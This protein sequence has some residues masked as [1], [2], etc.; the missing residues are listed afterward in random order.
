MAFILGDNGPNRLE[1]TSFSDTIEG[2]GGNDI[3][4]G[5]GGDDFLFGG[6]DNDDLIGGSGINE[7]T[8]DS[9][10][11]WFVMSGR[12]FADFS[13]D[14]ILDFE[15]GRDSIDVSAWG[16]SDF[17]QIRAILKADGLGDA[18]FDAMYDGFR[19][20][21]TLDNVRPNQLLSTDFIYSSSLGR[22]EVGTN[23][24][25][26]MF[27]SA[28]AD[29][30]EGRN[31]SDTLLGG[32]GD[33]ELFGQDGDDQLFGAAGDDTLEGG[34]GNDILTGASGRDL[35]DAGRGRDSLNGGTSHDTLFGG[36]G[37]DKMSGAGGNDRMEG[38][39]GNDSMSGGS[40]DDDLNG[41]SGRDVL[42][43]GSGEDGFIFTSASHSRPGSARDFIRDFQPGPDFIDVEAIDA[44]TRFFGNQDFEF[45]GPNA[46]T[47]AG[48]LRYFVSG[49]RTIVAGNTDNDSAAEFEIELF[50]AI[51]L[52][53]SDFI[54]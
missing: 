11:D 12:D 36:G 3:L 41:G 31:G 15:F 18:T 2:R 35:L 25:D 52:V 32:G 54:L 28:T 37:S 39:S 44:D 1:G 10:R 40:G 49:G 51:A 17:G 21:V 45:I 42:V 26:V 7:L 27:G 30:L 19:H 16:V 20:V 6:S 34:E 38:G 22:D 9:G 48:Q 29:I 4:D 33:D 53:Q 43:G 5:L 50:G 24:R 23:F 47:A 8:G 14:L 13:D 46:F